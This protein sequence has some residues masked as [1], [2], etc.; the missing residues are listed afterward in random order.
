MKSFHWI[1]GEAAVTFPNTQV[2]WLCRC[3]ETLRMS[4]ARLAMGALDA[5]T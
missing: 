2:S 1:F 3:D 5:G 4:M